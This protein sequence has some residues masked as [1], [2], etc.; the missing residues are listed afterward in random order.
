MHWSSQEAAEKEVSM[1]NQEFDALAERILLARLS[2]DLPVYPDDFAEFAVKTA[3]AFVTQLNQRREAQR[4][5]TKL[6]P[7]EVRLLENQRIIDA[8]KSVRVR[9]GM[10]LKGSKSFVDRERERLG[11]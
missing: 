1:T 2:C 10:D 6:N 11:L 4:T 8:I 7:E 3:D 9:T 5:S